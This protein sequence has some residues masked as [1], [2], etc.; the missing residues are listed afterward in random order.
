[1]SPGRQGLPEE[2]ARER[3]GNVSPPFSKLSAIF[4]GN[5]VLI[6]MKQNTE[7]RV[8]AWLSLQSKAQEA[9]Q[10]GDEGRGVGGVAGSK[11]EGQWKHP[12]Q[13]DL[14]PR[15][16]PGP[17]PFSWG[18]DMVPTPVILGLIS[19]ASEKGVKTPNTRG[20][21]RWERGFLH[22]SSRISSSPPGPRSGPP[23][24]WPPSPGGCTPAP[25]RGW[26]QDGVSLG[27]APH[28]VRGWSF[29]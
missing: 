12:V 6:L 26:R 13:P 22:Y 16:T 11:E 28:F 14:L 21:V 1:M 19:L 3:D 9:E 15:P 18:G 8:D 7:H 20:R 25:G 29:L 5:I 4:L 10:Q 23:Q 27:P 17:S 24:P 2:L